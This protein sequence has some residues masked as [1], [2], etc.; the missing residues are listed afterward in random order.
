MLFLYIN[1]NIPLIIVIILRVFHGPNE[2]LQVFE[3]PVAVW[4]VI[5]ADNLSSQYQNGYI[6]LTAN[7]TQ[8]KPV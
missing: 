5:R 6:I 7:V 4:S 1:K 3:C 2:H 8:L